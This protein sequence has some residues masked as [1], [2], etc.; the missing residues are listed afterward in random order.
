MQGL[1]PSACPGLW[2]CR[3]ALVFLRYFALY[4]VHCSLFYPM[5]SEVT[6]FLTGQ[7]GG[8]RGSTQKPWG[9]LVSI[10]SPLRVSLCQ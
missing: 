1:E 8:P 6:A 3:L 2:S 9:L 7:K 4:W 5:P 10:C